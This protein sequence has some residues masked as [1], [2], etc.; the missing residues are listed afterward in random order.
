MFVLCLFV[1]K[2]WHCGR[3]VKERPVNHVNQTWRVNQSWRV[4]HSDRVNYV[5]RSKSTPVITIQ[6]QLK[7]SLLQNDY[8]HTAL[9]HF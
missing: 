3:V 6:I 8:I 5:C 2:K 4:N 7:F 9:I 1:V